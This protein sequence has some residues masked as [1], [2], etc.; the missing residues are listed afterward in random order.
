MEI[1][2]ISVSDIKPYKNN[3]KKHSKKQVK[4]ISRSIEEFGMCD[5]IAVWGDENIIIEGHGRL[6]ALK[7]LG[8]E[9]VPIIR[10]DHLT[11]EQRKAYTLAHNKVAESEWDYE[12][13]DAEIN[14]IEGFDFEDFGFEFDY[15]TEEEQPKKKKNERLRTDAAY[16]LP[17]VDIERCEGKYQMPIIEPED[18]IPDSLIGF[19]YALTN[20]NKDTGVHFYVDDYQFERIWNE[21]EKYIDVLK[22]YDCVLTPDFSLYMDMP[23]SMKI[24][25]VFRSRLIGQMCQDAGLAVI[26]TVSWAEKETFD[27]CFDGLPEESVLSI[28]TIGVKNSPEAMEIWRAGVKELIKQKNPSTLLVYGGEVDF[29]YGDIEVLYFSNAVTERMKTGSKNKE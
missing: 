16:N 8:Y 28:S 18:F 6:E 15:D 13:L 2:E 9:T 27:F 29:D 1:V 26:P 17:Y 23:I 14:E 19:N 25:N 3:A 5:P 21:P 22:E 10:L 7:L 20:K 24:W 4:R 11:D 12:L